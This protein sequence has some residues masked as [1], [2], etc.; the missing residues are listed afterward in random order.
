MRRCF[1]YALC[2]VCYDVVCYDVVCYDVVVVVVALA[3]GDAGTSE[4]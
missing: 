2:V 4:I 3:I 1:I